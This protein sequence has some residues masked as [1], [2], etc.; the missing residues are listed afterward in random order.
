MKDII[1]MN[2]LAGLITE[3]QARKMIQ[4][5]NEGKF[6]NPKIKYLIKLYKEIG[7]EYPEE[8]IIDNNS[9]MTLEGELSIEEIEDMFDGE[10]LFDIDK[11]ELKDFLK[12]SQA[13]E[14]DI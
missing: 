10:D 6:T 7:D 2:Q 1:R 11:E 3:G 13:T 4:V 5:L 12:D 9:I 8:N 14:R